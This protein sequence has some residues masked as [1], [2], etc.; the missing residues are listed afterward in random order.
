MKD[1]PVLSLL[2]DGFSNMNLIVVIQMSISKKR[3]FSGIIH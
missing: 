2:L 1:S 3:P